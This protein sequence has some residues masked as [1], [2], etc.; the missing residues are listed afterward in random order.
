MGEGAGQV[1]EGNKLGA[2]GSD[3][4]AIFGIS[5]Y[6]AIAESKR[7]GGIGR[8]ARPEALVAEAGHHAGVALDDRVHLIVKAMANGARRRINRPHERDERVV[9]GPQGRGAARVELTAES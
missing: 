4:A 6:R 5:L 2:F 8:N 9:R 1:G 3:A 7:E